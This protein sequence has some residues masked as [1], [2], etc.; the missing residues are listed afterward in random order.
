MEAFH[1][2]S[3]KNFLNSFLDSF[4]NQRLDFRDSNW[5]SFSDDVPLIA[6]ITKQEFY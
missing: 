3:C 6:L 4:L 5:H 2:I 1:L